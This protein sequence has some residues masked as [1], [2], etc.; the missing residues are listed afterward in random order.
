MQPDEMLLDTLMPIIEEILCLLPT[1]D[2]IPTAESMHQ[3]RYLANK[4]GLHLDRIR[5]AAER[6]PDGKVQLQNKSVMLSIEF[7][8]QNHI[9]DIH[10]KPRTYPY[11]KTY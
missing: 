6:F 7:S 9:D 2:L 8:I 3:L 11:S 4:H 5:S 10:G 1:T